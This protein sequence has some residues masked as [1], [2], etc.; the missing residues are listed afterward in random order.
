MEFVVTGYFLTFLKWVVLP[1]NLLY[2][3]YAVVKFCRATASESTILLEE[4]V[5]I[6][7]TSAIIHLAVIVPFLGITVVIDWWRSMT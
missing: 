5:T 6:F 7:V 3:V 2:F 1:A 4:Y